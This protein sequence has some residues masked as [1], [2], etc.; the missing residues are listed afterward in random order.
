VTL[1]GVVLPGLFLLFFLF[2]VTCS[3]LSS[4][5]MVSSFIGLSGIAVAVSVVSCFPFVLIFM[6]SHLSSFMVLCR[7]A[8]FLSGTFG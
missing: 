8:L 7:D 2:S 6:G 1:C 3:D 5:R 4:T